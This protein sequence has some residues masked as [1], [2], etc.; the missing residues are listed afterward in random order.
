MKV[1]LCTV[2]FYTVY[3]ILPVFSPFSQ[4]WLVRVCFK[5]AVLH[6]DFSLPHALRGLEDSAGC[7]G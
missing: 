4:Y 2:F 7:V 1:S 3:V 5:P 6:P